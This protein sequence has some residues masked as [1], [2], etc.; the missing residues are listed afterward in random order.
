MSDHRQLRQAA[1]DDFNISGI[2]HRLLISPYFKSAIRIPQSAMD[3][4]VLTLPEIHSTALN[5]GGH[6]SMH[7][8]H[9]MH[10]V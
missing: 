10:L 3:H 5:L 4:P 1:T 7:P 8:P 2:R 6:T 9:L